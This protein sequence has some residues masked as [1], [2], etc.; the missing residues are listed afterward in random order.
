MK[1]LLTATRR[2][3]LENK[4]WRVERS[5]HDVGVTQYDEWYHTCC[6]LPSTL[7]IT[8]IDSY[9]LP[10]Y[11]LR[12]SMGY[13]KIGYHYNNFANQTLE[14][15]KSSKNVQDQITGELQN[16]SPLTW[17]SVLYSYVTT[18][19]RWNLGNCLKVKRKEMNM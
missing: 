9:M 16:V 4:K 8:K 15:Q 12:L 1:V 2:P 10:L 18:L 19:L 11:P 6:F 17:I 5:E 3:E 14:S 13:E 7:P